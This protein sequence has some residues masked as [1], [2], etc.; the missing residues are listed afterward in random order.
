[1]L[2][3][4]QKGFWAKNHVWVD[5]LDR[6]RE[7]VRLIS[8]DSLKGKTMIFFHKM[9][10]F[11]SKKWQKWIWKEIW[12][13]MDRMMIYFSDFLSNISMIQLTR[14]SDT[15]ESTKKIILQN[16]YRSKSM[17][18]LK[19]VLVKVHVNNRFKICKLSK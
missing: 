1:M 13:G 8:S 5:N 15:K 11:I 14:L 16:Y 19:K 17:S 2:L 9:E 12:N 6:A 18:Y 4:F 10:I 7:T 3:V